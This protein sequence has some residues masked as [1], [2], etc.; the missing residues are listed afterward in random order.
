MWETNW[1][2]YLAAI[3]CSHGKGRKDSEA[4]TQ[5]PES[6]SESSGDQFTGYRTDP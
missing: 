1:E 6:G 2:G 4:K 5:S 3:Q